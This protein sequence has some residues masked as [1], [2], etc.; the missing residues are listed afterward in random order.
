MLTSDEASRVID[1]IRPCFD[2][3]VRKYNERKY[4]PGVYRDLL[5]AFSSPEKLTPADLLRQPLIHEMALVLKPRWPL[6]HWQ[7]ANR[8]AL[9]NGFGSLILKQA[10]APLGRLDGALCSS[11]SIGV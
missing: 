11:T 4:P 10:C 8:S 7:A 6:D 2:V 9:L 3:Y 5:R 1:L